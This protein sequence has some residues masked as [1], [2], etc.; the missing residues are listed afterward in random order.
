[1]S[2]VINNSNANSA[3][4]NTIQASESMTMSSVVYSTEPVAPLHAMQY[5]P[6]DKA[7]G[8]VSANG[9]MHFQIPKYG[10][11]SQCLLS[12]K[13]KNTGTDPW[14]AGEAFDF[15]HRIK[16]VDLLSSSRTISTLT[17]ADLIAQFS[18]LKQTQFNPVFQSCLKNRTITVGGASST[19]PAG[20][21]L[22][23]TIP[24]V[25]GLFKN[26]NT[27][28]S[29]SFNEPCQIRVNWDNPSYGSF[30][31]AGPPAVSIVIELADPQLKIRYKSYPEAATSQMLAEN[32]G[33]RP[34]LNMLSTRWYDE[35]P[36]DHTHVGGA[37]ALQ[38]VKVEL[39]NTEVVSDFFVYARAKQ[40]AGTVNVYKPQQIEN[41]ILRASGQELLNLTFHELAFMKLDDEGYANQIGVSSDTAGTANV[42]KVQTGV[43]D[44]KGVSNGFSLREMNSVEM[45]L[46]IRPDGALDDGD[47]YEIVVAE[48]CLAI[49]AVSSST[50]RLTLSLAN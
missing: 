26:E 8:S 32:Y 12:Y 9:Q 46:T 35:N 22:D 14:T 1:M 31:A 5:L 21:Q 6:V 49:Y 11:M 20:G 7:S 50:G 15:C 43:Y 3:L 19:I 47:I 37:G 38:T 44:Q 29:T 30:S 10:T 25:F 33:D 27:Q 24:L 13:L 36:K 28:I 18:D 45:E 17:R 34:E 48:R 39:R 23:F 40:A 2:S 42:A 4:V 16:S 41:L